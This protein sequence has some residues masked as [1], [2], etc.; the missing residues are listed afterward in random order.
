MCSSVFCKEMQN[1]ILVKDK[2]SNEIL[3]QHIHA[4]VAPELQQYFHFYLRVDLI[5]YEA[6]DPHNHR[7]PPF[8]Y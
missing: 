7:L 6:L 5:L 4:Q 8:L 1:Q 3:P 2:V